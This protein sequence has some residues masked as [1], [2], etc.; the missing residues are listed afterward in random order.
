MT[1]DDLYMGVAPLRDL[2]QKGKLRWEHPITDETEDLES[3]IWNYPTADSIAADTA[4]FAADEISVN[5]ADKNVAKSKIMTVFKESDK[6]GDGSISVDEL[7]R[8]FEG[9]DSEF[10]KDEIAV[11]FQA[12]D[13]NNDGRL[14]FAEFLD[15]LFRAGEHDFDWRA[16]R[17]EAAD[18]EG[19]EVVDEEC[20]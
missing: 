18:C 9:I 17:A 13:K 20:E 6:D 3:P 4:E 16:K 1:G 7:V 11:M 8:V 2:V 12:V 15:W 19:E 5:L 10:S 14:D